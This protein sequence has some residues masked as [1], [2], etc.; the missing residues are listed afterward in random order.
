ME[1]LKSTNR[2]NAFYPYSRRII[3]SIF[4]SVPFDA[5]KK[6][7]KETNHMVDFIVSMALI[8]LNWIILKIYRLNHES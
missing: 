8:L 3:G 2:V 4:K 7:V 6:T 5:T 1:I